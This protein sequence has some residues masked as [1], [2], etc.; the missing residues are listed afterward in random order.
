[1]SITSVSL[2]GSKVFSLP[3][4]DS[5]ISSSNAT[6]ATKPSSACR[7]RI[8]TSRISSTTPNLFCSPTPDSLE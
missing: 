5:R 7:V 4:V 2:S 8:T 1:M 6:P 3:I